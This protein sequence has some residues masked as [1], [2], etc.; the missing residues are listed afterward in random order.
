MRLYQSK[1]TW[2]CLAEYPGLARRMAEDGYLKMDLSFNIFAMLSKPLPDHCRYA[3][4]FPVHLKLIEKQWSTPLNHLF[5]RFCKTLRD[6]HRMRY[7]HIFA[8]KSEGI[9]V[10]HLQPSR[11]TNCVIQ[12]TL[13]VEVMCV[14]ARTEIEKPICIL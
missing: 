2:R 3:E 4:G 8:N 9:Q 6:I 10:Q 1:S 13:V 7:L 14:S 12:Q 11:G 5:L